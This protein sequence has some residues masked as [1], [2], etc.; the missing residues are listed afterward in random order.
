MATMNWIQRYVTIDEGLPCSVCGR[1]A[2]YKIYYLVGPTDE[3][4]NWIETIWRRD[5]SGDFVVCTKCAE[6]SYGCPG[7]DPDTWLE[8]RILEYQRGTTQIQKEADGSRNRR[9]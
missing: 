8:S 7:V 6:E 1:V 9:N 5:P 2:R 3:Q 4:A